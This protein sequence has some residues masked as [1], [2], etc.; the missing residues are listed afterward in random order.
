MVSWHPR[1]LRLKAKIKNNP[2]YRFQS[3]E[4]IAIAAELNISIDVNSATVDDWLRLPGISIRQAQTLTNLTAAGIQFFSLEDI[5]AAL[6][7]PLHRLQ[8]F[9]PILSFSFND[10]ESEFTPSSIN[11][12]TATV[13]EL[14]KVPFFDQ[15]LAEKVVD[16]RLNYGNYDNLADFHRRLALDTKL[17]SQ[18]MHYLHFS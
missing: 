6:N 3:L 7:L 14:A 16:N 2:Y 4:E 1:V 17:T 15:S 5:A 12:N 13:E 9:A 11:P 8:P 18:L 10:P